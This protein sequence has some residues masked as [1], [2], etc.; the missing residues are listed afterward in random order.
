MNLQLTKYKRIAI[1]FCLAAS[2]SGYSLIA[3]EYTE[4]QVDTLRHKGDLYLLIGQSNMAGYG[5]IAAYNDTIPNVW[6]LKGQD[7]QLWEKAA[8]PMVKY[9]TNA[10]PN[11][12]PSSADYPDHFGLHYM[13]AKKMHEHTP[14][15]CIGLVVN[16]RGDTSIDEWQ[17]GSQLLDSA[18][19]RTRLA[20]HSGNWTLK[21]I[22]WMQGEKDAYGNHAEYREKLIAMVTYL[23][24]ALNSDAA[25]VAGQIMPIAEYEEWNRDILL[26][27][28]CLENCAVASSEGCSRWFDA[29]HFDTNSCNLIGERFAEK[30]IKLLAAKEKPRHKKHRKHKRKNY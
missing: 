23:R 19:S 18:L 7:H 21:G 22:L 14:D 6:L 15:K 12:L 3:G 2:L 28:D 4:I 26:L 10:H 11:D 27:P 1:G 16:P 17:P 25:F 8:E 9:A 30:M 24:N 29:I 13:F 5:K 20:L